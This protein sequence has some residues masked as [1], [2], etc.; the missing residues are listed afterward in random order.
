MKLLILI[1]I[2]SSALNVFADSDETKEARTNPIVVTASHEPT[3]YSEVSR[4]VTIV[5]FEQIENAPVKNLDELLEYVSSVDVRRRGGP[6]AQADYS[7]RG[8]SFDQAMILLNGIPFNSPQTGHHNGNLPISINDIE[9]I[10]VLEGSGGR[11][12]GAN[13]FSGG[14][15]IITKQKSESKSVNLSLSGGDYGYYDM[16]MSSYYKPFKN[17]STYYSIYRQKSDG[18]MA[19]TDT[20]LLNAYGVNTLT[21]NAGEFSLQLGANKREFGANSFYT[22]AY[23]NQ[24]EATTS[25]FTSLCYKFTNLSYSISSQAYYKYHFDRFELFRASKDAPAWYAGHN[26]HQTDI[27]GGDAKITLYSSLG[28]TTIGAEA[29]REHIYSNVLGATMSKPKKV[30]GTKNSYYT[31]QDTRDNASL[32]L[33]HSL[34]FGRAN[35]SF[36]A[37]LNANSDFSPSIYS[38]IDASY[39]IADGIAVFGS[40]NQSGRIPSFTDLYYNGPTNRGNPN[41]VPEQSLSFETGVKYIDSRIN[42]SLS[43]FNNRGKNLIDWIKHPDSTIW[44]TK[45]LTKLNTVGFQTS[46]AIYPTFVLNNQK[47]IKYVSISYTYI[48]SEKSSEDLQSLYAL[49]YLRHKFA[50]GIGLGLSNFGID[51]RASYQKRNGT[52]FSYV[53]NKDMPYKD[54]F[55][56]GTRLNYKIKPINVYFDADNIFDNSYQDIANVVQPGRW[57]RL[58][59]DVEIK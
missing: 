23:P 51:I 1:G 8:G 26:Y 12:L 45:N 27:V 44:E 14:I 39:K 29:R 20:D 10:E 52:Y 13:A 22:A 49:D 11:A 33:E 36:G 54:I 40:I 31:R 9:R 53:E 43:I 47:L 17:F 35:V 4:I 32:F 6:S 55:L 28:N 15:N 48:T 59:I 24:F 2:I 50:F 46:F 57:V 34:E 58:G 3:V 19:N 38:G 5:P 16:S 7:I 18:Y 30:S 42:S 25:A 21:T 41:L 56:V 37:M